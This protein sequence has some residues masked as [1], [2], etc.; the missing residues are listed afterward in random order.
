MTKRIL[1]S[2]IFAS[3]VTGLTCIVF[4]M[5]ILYDYF[6]KSLLNEL[7][8]EATLV[9]QGVELYG[10]K[11][12]DSLETEGRITWIDSDGKVLYDTD[13]DAAS[14]ENHKERE[15]VEEA[16]EYGSGSSQRYSRTFAE[17]NVYYAELMNDG[18]VIRVSSSQYSIWSLIMAMVQPVLFVSVLIIILSVFLA[19]KL[20]TK[21]VKPINDIDLDHPD[22]DEDY[23]E[24]SPLLK[25]ISK[26]NLLIDRQMKA[27]RKNEEAFM[28]ITSNMSEG[29]III[30]K[31]TGILSFNNGALKLL[32]KNNAEI[33]ESVFT[34]DRSERFREGISS[35]LAGNH[36]ELMMEHD[37]RIYQLLAN[38]VFENDD[39]NGAVILIMDVTEREQR[40]ALRKEFT[41]NVSHELRTPLTSIF[42][43]SEIMM[44]GIVKPE[45]MAGF[46]ANIHDESGRLINLVNDIIKL[47]Q[48]DENSITAQKEPVDIFA[49]AKSIADRLKTI[50]SKND[51]TINVSGEK[52]VINGINYILDEII[53]NL[54]ENAVKYNKTGGEVNV[55]VGIEGNKP[56][57]KV[58]DTGI[59]IPKDQCSRIFERFYRVDKSHS[60]KIGGTGLGL[61]IVKH[62][63]AFHNAHIEVNSKPGE[64]TVF[65]VVFD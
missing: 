44:N 64:G 33:G 40:E 26:Q 50:A 63:A 62:G 30:D 18:T 11:Y 4:I 13:A 56:I 29:L 43:V 46:A 52:T 28:T 48:L 1:R 39:V 53:Y 32:G 37:G 20:S 65:T 25:K 19:A 38:P 45:D 7:K 51:V 34:L 22:I 2:I 3:I 41:S 10:E 6:N 36:S 9:E 59:G 55:F 17:R 60:R 42:G 24:I 58:S 47:S 5:G 61:S 8:I 16:F 35:A 23:P 54:C 31:G 27:L 12:F 49:M 57:I 21:I 15:E 14:L